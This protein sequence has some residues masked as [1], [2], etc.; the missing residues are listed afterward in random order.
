MFEHCRDGERA[1]GTSQIG[2]DVEV[3]RSD[4]FDR[5]AGLLWYRQ[6]DLNFVVL[7]AVYQIRNSDI[8][9]QLV[10]TGGLEVDVLTHMRS[11]RELLQD[12]TM[13]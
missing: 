3:F 8:A 11:F 7:C 2:L 9:S 10:M 12:F 13:P 4:F 5:L 6:E 1:A